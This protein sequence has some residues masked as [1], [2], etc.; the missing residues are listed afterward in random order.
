[1]C[2]ILSTMVQLLQEQCRKSLVKDE[3]GPHTKEGIIIL[4]NT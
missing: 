4:G 2:V 3:G 1:M